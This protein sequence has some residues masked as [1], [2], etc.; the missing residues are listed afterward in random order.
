MAAV[1]DKVAVLLFGSSEWLCI[2]AVWMT[3]P[4]LVPELPE[5]W[6][7]PSRLALVSNEKCTNVLIA[8]SLQILQVAQ[9][10]PLIYSVLK[11]RCCNTNRATVLAI[12]AIVR[13]RT[14]FKESFFTSANRGNSHHGLVVVYLETHCMDVRLACEHRSVHWHVPVG[15]MCN[16]NKHCISPL[17]VHARLAGY[18]LK[19]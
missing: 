1:S 18:G 3:L 7:L 4:I 17:R 13:E 11:R 6:T 2:N 10:V 8:S 14:S 5:K 12:W 16:I 9:I 19:R 15:R